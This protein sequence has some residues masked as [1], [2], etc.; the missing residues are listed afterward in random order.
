[1]P[2]VTY[3]DPEIGHVGKYARDLEEQKQ[4]YDT[5]KYDFFHSDRA[6]CDE[7]EGFLKVHCAK[8]TDTILGCTIVGGPAGEMITH[9]TSAMFN[10]VGL[11]TLGQGVTPYPVYS[12]AIK[13]VSG[14]VRGKIAKLG[15]K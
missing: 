12:E 14:Q 8:D 3:T 10:K 1:M 9:M 13:A 11:A 7:A 5:Y 15:K 2:W 6:I 4:E